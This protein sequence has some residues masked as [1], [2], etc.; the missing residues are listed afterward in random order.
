VLAQNRPPRPTPAQP[1]EPDPPR[2]TAISWS[3]NDPRAVIAYQE[4]SYSVSPGQNFEG[5][6]VVSIA[7]ERVV[8]EKDGRSWVLTLRPRGE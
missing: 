4:R 1:A 2:L 5:F 8:V 7:P 6:R 3:S